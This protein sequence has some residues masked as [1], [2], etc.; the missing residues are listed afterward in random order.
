[1]KNTDSKQIQ[2][3]NINLIPFLAESFSTNK[4][5]YKD[6]DK[7][8]NTD[9][10]RFLNLAKKDEFYNHAMAQEG[11]IEQEYYFKKALGIIL[12][13]ADDE[14]ITE[15]VRN[16]CK[17]G[18]K[19]AFTYINQVNELKL[20]TFLDRLIRKNNGI[21]NLTDDELNSNMVVIMFLATTKEINICESDEMYYHMAMWFVQRMEHYKKEN[22]INIDNLPKEQLK[23]L[24]EYELRIK[25]ENKYDFI[26]SGF[27]LNAD[28]QQGVIIKSQKLS[29]EDK[30]LAALEYIFDYEGLSIISIVGE[31]YLK[32]KEIQELLY[33]YTCL[34]Q[35]NE[36]IDFNDLVKFLYPAIQMRYLCKEYKKAK[37]YFFENFEEGL[38]EEL[39]VLE[40]ENREVKKSNLLVQDENERLKLRVAELERENKR[41][42]Q[43]I[44]ER[45]DNKSEI[46]ALREFIFNLEEEIPVQ[47]NNTNYE[48]LNEYRG[49]IVGGHDSWRLK[50]KEILKDW[51]FIGVEAINFDE[52]IIRNSDYVF[53]N[54][55]YLSHAM[56]YKVMSIVNRCDKKVFFVNN[57]NVELVLGE[58]WDRI[59]G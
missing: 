42:K 19:Y 11:N 31:D 22:R 59:K 53:I 43:E 40:N 29:K 34:F 27:R 10:L 16:I 4:K 14:L 24:R 20:S 41:L 26:P 50:L 17:K 57:Y 54:V 37:S 28:Q 47:E 36:D 56:Y 15:E 58:M 51:T 13:G 32:S 33:A 44:D 38:Y 46:T 35:G 6:I 49:A 52:D 12:A 5:I 21:D 9:K 2:E 7:V 18:W 30:F 55:G 45:E 23:K 3:V 25:N 39:A 48:A 8:Y 1:M